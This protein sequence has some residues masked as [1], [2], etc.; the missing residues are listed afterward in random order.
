MHKSTFEVLKN[1]SAINAGILIRKGDEVRTVSVEKNILAVAKVPDTFT[2]EFAIYNLNE[3]LSTIR[4]FDKPDVAYNN[5]HVLLSDKDSRVKYRYSS[6]SVVV[7]APEKD[8]TIDDPIIEF[9][10]SIE[11]LERLT[12][13]AAVM[14]FSTL[15]ISSGG[16]RAF[17]NKAGAGNE[18]RSTPTNIKS[19]PGAQNYNIAINLLKVIPANYHVKVTDRFVQLQGTV[20]GVSLSYAIAVDTGE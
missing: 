13:A 1:F 12:K 2:Q 4:L 18:F 11:Y 7:A 9:D 20:D 3:F 10:L 14:Q 6:P 17:N 5:D 19:Q 15:E 8:L 16:L